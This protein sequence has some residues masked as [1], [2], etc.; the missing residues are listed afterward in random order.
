MKN[1]WSKVLKVDTLWAVFSSGICHSLPRVTWNAQDCIS[2]V[3][4]TKGVWSISHQ[5]TLDIQVKIWI[6]CEPYVNQ[7]L[8]IYILVHGRIWTL[9]KKVAWFKEI[10]L[11]SCA[12][13]IGQQTL[14]LAYLN[15]NRNLFQH[16]TASVK[17]S[18]NSS[19]TFQYP[20]NMV[21]SEE[22]SEN[23]L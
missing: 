17:R 4:T 3:S 18:Q 6:L 10:N 1:C 20:T 8:L 21:I 12:C 7:F 9:R 5:S 2:G 11:S 22:L 13:E 19:L 23:V 14:S 15:T 16:Q